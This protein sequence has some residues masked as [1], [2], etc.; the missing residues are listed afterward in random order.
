MQKI[1]VVTGASSGI[2]LA[3]AKRLIEKGYKVYCLS[4]RSE[5]A[6][7][8]IKADITSEEEVRNAF[9]E[10]EKAEGRIDLLVNNAGLGISGAVEFTELSDAKRIFDVNFFGAFLCTKYAMEL[11]RK[12][13]GR[14]INISS[15]AAIFSI[16]FQGFYSA[17][18]SA[19]NAL[20]LAQRSESEM[21][22]VSVCAI[23]PGDTK[24][25]FTEARKKNISGEELYKS[26]IEAS[27][28]LMEKD[29]EKGMSA[30]CVA[31]FIC[32]VAEKRRVAPLYTVGLKYKAFYLLSKLLPTRLI[33][34][35]VSKLYIK[36]GK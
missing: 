33:N 22:G 20:T 4:R 29:E 34:Y 13:K 5:G 3:T 31:R 8:H 10:I 6:A 12:S 14:V 15:P 25:G 17:T 16:P 1:A 27:V 24:T 2:G 18:K 35:V 23:M 21:L 28:A 30:E 9:A 7:I 11:L 19:L 26:S 32:S 36:R